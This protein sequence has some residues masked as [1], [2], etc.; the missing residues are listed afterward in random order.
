MSNA[1]NQSRK[2]KITK[3]SL[4]RS[5]KTF[6]SNNPHS[7]IEA[8]QNSKTCDWVISKPWNDNTLELQIPLMQKRKKRQSRY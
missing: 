1:K 5:L 6:L 2:P 7:S 3:S 4:S 8:K